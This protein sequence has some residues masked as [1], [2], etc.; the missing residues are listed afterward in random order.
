MVDTQVMAVLNGI[1]D[2]KE[3]LLREFILTNVLTALCDIQ[4]EV[5]L[6]AV[7]ENNIDAVRVVHNLQH[8]HHIWVRRCVVVQAN[9]SLLVGN[10]AAFQWCSIGIVLAQAL[11]SIP[12]SS[13]DIQGSV[14]DTICAGTKNIS[15]LELTLKKSSYTLFWGKGHT[16]GLESACRKGLLD[17]ALGVVVRGR[18]RGSGISI[19]GMVLHVKRLVGGSP[20]GSVVQ[21]FKSSA[22]PEDGEID[23]R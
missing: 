8:G 19:R 21:G 12:N 10:L 22:R 13:V 1:Q 17:V 16:S 5:T 11:Y 15:E 18:G 6:W 3:H 4:E 2:L 9:L 7:L 14:N 23:I 20:K